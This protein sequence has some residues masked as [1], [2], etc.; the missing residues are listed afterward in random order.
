MAHLPSVHLLQSYAEV[1][2]DSEQQEQQIARP[3]STHTKVAQIQ[4]CSIARRLT[5]KT[6]HTKKAASK[7]QCQHQISQLGQ[8]MT[9]I[10][11]AI[12]AEL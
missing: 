1:V 6:T 2:K 4:G 5:A 10:P 7:L 8:H 9:A 12:P 11:A 3:D